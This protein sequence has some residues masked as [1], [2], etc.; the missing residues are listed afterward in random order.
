MSKLFY[1]NLKP[2]YYTTF[3]YFT[4]KKSFRN[5]SMHNEYH[6]AFLSSDLFP[7]YPRPKMKNLIS[8]LEN[9]PTRQ[10]PTSHKYEK[11]KAYFKSLPLGV[12]P[13][14]RTLFLEHIKL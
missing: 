11:N 6:V 1:F 4:K 10:I 2:E 8:C 7:T 13:A 14:S 12:F 3:W 9:Q 5:S